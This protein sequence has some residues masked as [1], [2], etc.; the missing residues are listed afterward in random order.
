MIKMTT[1]ITL[2][3]WNQHVVIVHLL[4]LEAKKKYQCPEE[5]KFMQSDGGRSL[6]TDSEQVARRAVKGYAKNFSPP[7]A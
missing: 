2:V 5:L 1:D 3:T 4:Q 7:R 6:P